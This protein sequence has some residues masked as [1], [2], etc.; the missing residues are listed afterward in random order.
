MCV[1]IRLVSYVTDAAPRTFPPS[2]QGTPTPAY[3]TVMEPQ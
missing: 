1:S 3:P 2:Y